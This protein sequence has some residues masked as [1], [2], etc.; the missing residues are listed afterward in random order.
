MKLNGQHKFKKLTGAL[1]LLALL[2]LL[3]LLTSCGLPSGNQKPDDS[4]VRDG[5]K[6]LVTSFERGHTKLINWNDAKVKAQINRPIPSGFA[7]EAGWNIK[8]PNYSQGELPYV[9]IPWAVIGQ[10]PTKYALDGSFY[11]GGKI[12]PAA[13]G[14]QI[15]KIQQANFQNGDEF[16]AA[17]VRQR[18]SSKDPTWLIYT[19]VPYLPVTDNAY[20]FAHIT[21]GVWKIMDFGTAT[22]GCG[23]VP[24]AVQSEF[25]FTCPSN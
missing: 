24:Q 15:A 19:S 13:V 9:V 8:W 20:G 11:D 10:Y 12:V 7:T 23:L 2:A 5:I 4:K 6:L 16:F 22:V 1:T 3:T 18:F 21:N 17:T 14:L 25:G